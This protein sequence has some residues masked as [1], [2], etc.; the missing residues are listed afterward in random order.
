VGK[1]REEREGRSGMSDGR[2][3]SVSFT[4]PKR[5]PNHRL[6]TALQRCEPIR[7]KKGLRVGLNRAEG[8]GKTET[9]SSASKNKKGGT[10]RHG[11]MRGWDAT[12]LRKRMEENQRHLDEP[13][14]V[15]CY[16]ASLR[17][18]QTGEGEEL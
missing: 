16:G 5:T 4:A 13:K 1:D 2:K 3:V 18:N 8:A 14:G 7:I 10:A 6:C 9:P 12:F 11:K 17:G 15:Q